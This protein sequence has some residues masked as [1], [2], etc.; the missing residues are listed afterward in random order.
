MVIGAVAVPLPHGV[1]VFLPVDI[2]TES[3]DTVM[4]QSGK[5]FDVSQNLI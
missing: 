4:S 3:E 1:L 2:P 5:C